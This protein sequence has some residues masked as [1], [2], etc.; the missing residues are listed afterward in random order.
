MRAPL[1]SVQEIFRTW[2]N[3]MLT[4]SVS[5]ISN[6]ATAINLSLPDIQNMFSNWPGRM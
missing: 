4:H 2:G 3:R 6:R 1:L 5:Y